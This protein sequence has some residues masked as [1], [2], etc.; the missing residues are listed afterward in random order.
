MYY[1]ISA[2][3]YPITLT[4]DHITYYCKEVLVENESYFKLVNSNGDVAV[5]YSVGYGSCWS[6]DVYD[7]FEKKQL[8]LDSRLI[9]YIASSEFKSKFKDKNY[10][11]IDSSSKLLYNKF[12]NNLFSEFD[13]YNLPDISSFCQLHVSFIPMDSKFKVEEYDGNETIKIFNPDDY[14]IA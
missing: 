14:I 6:A 3:D 9:Q 11:N 10:Y 5:A 7:I 12:I 2:M 13:M 4:I 1:I 8:L